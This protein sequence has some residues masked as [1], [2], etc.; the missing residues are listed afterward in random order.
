MIGKNVRPGLGIGQFHFQPQFD[1]TGPDQGGGKVG[2][3][4]GG[5]HDANPAGAFAFQPVD[6]GQQ[7]A[8][9][10]AFLSVFKNGVC[11]VDENDRGGIVLGGFEHMVNAVVKALGARDESSV[12]QEEL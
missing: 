8:I 3:V 4:H 6:H 10:A 9:Q 2:D 12:D 11:V 1:A 7:V 5:H